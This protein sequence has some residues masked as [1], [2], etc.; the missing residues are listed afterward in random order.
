VAAPTLLVVSVAIALWLAFGV[1][2]GEIARYIGYQLAYVVLPGL[3][4]YRAL[5]GSSNGLL[6]QVAFGWA[7]GYALEIVAYMVTSG[8]GAPGL[9]Y[10]Y[11]LVALPLAGGFALRR[12]PD[13]EASTPKRAAPRGWSWAVAVVCV[14]ALGLV[15][16]SLFVQT[17]LPG[18][19]A[20][21]DYDKD[22]V[23]RLSFAGEAKHHWPPTDPSIA[24]Q[25]LPYHYFPE[26][27]A[28]AVSNVTGLELAT[29]LF[30][31]DVV[32]AVC[33]FAVLVSV[34]GS[35]FAASAWVGPLGAGLLLLVGEPDIAIGEVRPF[36]G[37]LF[38]RVY[39]DPGWLMGAIFLLPSLVLLYERTGSNERSALVA[40]GPWVACAVLLLGAAGSKPASLPVVLG[41]LVLFGLWQVATERRLSRAIPA[42]IAVVAALFVGFFFT[43]YGQGASAGGRLML[44]PLELV[45]GMNAVESLDDLL[46]EGLGFAPSG[47]VTFASMGLGLVGLIAPIGIMVAVLVAWHRFRLA[48]HQVWLLAF[49]LAGLTLTLLLGHPGN[50]QVY[51]YELGLLGGALLAAELLSRFW[52]QARAERSAALLAGGAAV[53]LLVLVV[54]GAV[55]GVY[56]PT[57]GST[58]L[59]ALAPVLA[60]LFGGLAILV[61]AGLFRRRVRG[62][63]GLAIALAAVLFSGLADAPLDAASAAT[64]GGTR[65]Y[66]ETEVAPG[67]PLH[68][69]E[70]DNLTP[71]L[72][73]GLRWVRENTDP[74]AVLAVNNQFRDE[75]REDAR[76]FYYSALSER[77]MLLESWRY[78][79][80][81]ADLDE[82]PFPERAA[83][84]RA[85]LR[86]DEGAIRRAV[87]DHGLTHVLIDKVHGG[88][89]A[90]RPP[91]SGLVFSNRDIDVYALSQSDRG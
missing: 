26:V 24:G 29:L 47:L 60:V 56:Q 89:R 58:S 3:L 1:G 87:A 91:R 38:S 73:A 79:A 20:A 69:T 64:P 7:L 5:G 17:P 74:S 70:N 13:R 84:N 15:A 77:R 68:S 53:G 61:V 9:F 43:L 23:R 76:Y 55:L 34:V 54:G 36:V 67:E 86:G 6:R 4:A 49:Y 62:G 40:L 72:L 14:A 59:R 19:V 18:T 75:D 25:P 50:S 52:R 37:G 42:G 81:T 22:G 88:S 39:S 71:G 82:Q 2:S 63:V 10:A 8:L 80:A 35:R 78:W 85:I 51:F 90:T 27:H 41:A 28:A 46:V 30:R 66:T 12:R 83:L 65:P 16:A 32:A 57:E 48:R 31:L 44:A 45:R 11:P 21:V 33:L